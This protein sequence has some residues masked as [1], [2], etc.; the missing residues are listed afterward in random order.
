[1]PGQL[2]KNTSELTMTPQSLNTRLCVCSLVLVSIC[3][4]SA[5]ETLHSTWGITLAVARALENDHISI[6]LKIAPWQ[7]HRLYLRGTCQVAQQS[8]WSLFDWGREVG[9]FFFF[10][11]CQAS[12]ACT[13]GSWYSEQNQGICIIHYS[14]CGTERRHRC[15]GHCGR[16]S[17]SK[18]PKVKKKQLT[19]CSCFSISLQLT[20]L[21]RA[22][23]ISCIS[24]LFSECFSCRVCGFVDMH[25]SA[26]DDIKRVMIYIL[27]G[28]C[29]HGPMLSEMHL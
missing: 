9:F 21:S 23:S 16:T 2:K 20:S 28:R 10:F 27:S 4:W 1:M 22:C 3:V 26:C 5:G 25:S 24:C 17:M 18:K 14:R 11:L 13:P 29:L 7:W 6:F 8:V 15:P 19:T 12:A